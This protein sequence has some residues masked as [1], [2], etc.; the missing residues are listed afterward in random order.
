M[1]GVFGLL[2]T[3]MLLASAAL[4]DG[5]KAG[6]FDYYVL[7]LGWSPSWCALEGDRRVSDQCDPRHDFGF[8]LHGLWPQFTV[9]WPSYCPTA[10]RPPS[11]QMT[12]DMADI[13][14][15]GGLAWHQW[16]KHGRCSGLSAA[17]YYAQARAAFEA[18]A[19]PE[20]FRQMH[21]P[22]EFPALLVEQAFIKANPKL[23][24]ET[25]TVICKAG[26]FS[27][28]RICLDKDLNPRACAPDTARDCRQRVIF[29]PV[30]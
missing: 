25:I 14:G 21:A 11:R 22:L 29:P 19:K 7:S 15:S 13:M 17:A 6:R 24:P 16:D 8:T 5:D 23:A 1:R 18:V 12:A 9:G 28:V 30:R 2:A 3:L 26:Y 27:E 10:E 20:V 4:A